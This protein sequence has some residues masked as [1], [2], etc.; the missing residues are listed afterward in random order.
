MCLV[1]LVT[2][3]G[4]LGHVKIT[5]V[6]L[7]FVCIESFHLTSLAS[8][9]NLLLVPIKAV[10]TFNKDVYASADN[11]KKITIT[12]NGSSTQY[13]KNMKIYLRWQQVDD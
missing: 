3:V 2:M 9:M 5:A 12:E 11:N 8:A 6:G 7:G 10:V 1:S 4:E 13:A